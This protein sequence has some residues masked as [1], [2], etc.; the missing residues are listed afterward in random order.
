MRV[1][2]VTN[3]Y[4]TPTRTNFGIIVRRLEAALKNIGVEVRVEAIAGERGATDYLL[5]RRRVA[6]SA[7]EFRPDVVHAH[8]GYSA[9]ATTSSLPRVVSFYG[10]DLNGEANGRGSITMRSRVGRYVSW[11]AAL[12]CE[13]SIAVSAALRSTLAVS[14]ARDRCE[15]LRDGVDTKLFSPGD[16]LAARCRLGMAADEML[17]LF[18][19]AVHIPTKRVDLAHAAID[20]LRREGTPAR[21]WV[22][23]GRAP[24]EMPD[25]Y[26]AAD[27]LVVTSELEG[28]PS[29]VKEALAC[30]L[31]VVSVPVG[32]VDTLREVPSHCFVA[33]RDPSSIAAKLLLAL[34]KRTHDR[35]SLLPAGLS[36]SET[37]EKL[38]LVYEDAIRRWRSAHRSDARAGAAT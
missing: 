4:P 30:G 37:A 5:A 20:V 12:A 32:D 19:H 31:P 35:S 23:N 9:L 15:V 34:Q 22:V 11:W 1:L 26:R 38:L 36:L 17:V 7:Q 3:M 14:S 18:P 16:R 21:L 13:R 8:F 27:V 2:F 28:G 6:A 24:D 33:E 29:S 10:D 25:Y